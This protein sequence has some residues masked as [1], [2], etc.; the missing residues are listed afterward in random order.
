MATQLLDAPP[1]QTTFAK[2]QPW[3]SLLM[4]LGLVAV[5]L[6]SGL[7][8][9]GTPQQSVMAV[10]AYE[11]PLPPALVNVIGWGLPWF[12]IA[13]GLL[14]LAGLLTR[15]AAIASA[16]VLVLF[17]AGIISAWARGLSIDCGC[18]GGGGQVAPDQTSYAWTLLRDAGFALMAGWL[19][20][21]PRSKFSL[22]R[23]G[24]DDEFVVDD[25]ENE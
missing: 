21:F 20:L 6:V 4:R 14:L 12:E 19:I 3:L 2:A 16:V 8:K 24:E 10:E 1:R 11:L 9:V 23:F 18:F 17:M 13:L 22:D 25:E 7:L 5:W 15:P